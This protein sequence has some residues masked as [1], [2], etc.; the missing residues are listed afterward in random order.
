MQS[1]RLNGALFAALLLAVSLSCGSPLW[2]QVVG[3]NLNGIVS[4]SSG[5]SI[6]SAQISITDVATGVG[7]AVTTD[8]A[9]LYTAPNLPAGKYDVT[10]TA[11]GFSTFVRNGLTLTVGESL[12][13]NV[14]LQVGQVKQQV[15]VTGEAPAVET[16]SSEMSAVVNSA[17]IEDLP[18]NGRSWTDLTI[19]QRG[20]SLI[21]SGEGEAESG[22]CNH[23]CGAELSING[24]RP[25]QNNY[26]IDGISI[27]DQINSAP[28]SQAGGGNLGVDTIQEFSV[29]TDNQSAEYGRTAGGVINSITR[30]G[31]NDIHGTAFEFIRNSALDA[32]NFFDPASGPPEFR[33]NQFGGSFGGPIQK[34]KTFFFGAYE[35]LR[36]SLGFTAIDLVPSA[37][38]H[39]GIL[40]TG[41]VTVDP[42]IQLALK[43]FP[44]PNGK[45]ITPDQGQFIFIGNDVTNE[46]FFDGKV[47]HTFS[48]HDSISGT[49]Q[50]DRASGTNPDNFGI[51]LQENLTERQL[52]TVAETHIFSSTIVNTARFGWTRFSMPIGLSAGV[53]N[54]AGNNPA[55]ATVPGQPGQAAISIGAGFTANPGG[56][57]TQAHSF[58][59]FNTW[60]YHDDLFVTSGKHSLKFGVAVEHDQDIY[61]NSTATGGSWSFPGLAAFLQNEPKSLTALVPGNLTA[62]RLHTTIAGG[63][64]QD[65]FR[66]RPSLTLNLGLRYEMSTVPYETSGKVT[67]LSNLFDANPRIGNP[68]W[69]NP[70]YRNFEPRLGFAWDPFR[71]GKTSIRGGF[72]MF[73]V[74]PLF[75]EVTTQFA[76]GYPF[77]LVGATT[78]S[79][80]GPPAAG[81]G[82][83]PT[84]G[85]D[86]CIQNGFSSFRGL[87]FQNDPKRNYV[88]QWNMDIQH[89]LTPSV[90]FSVGYVGTKSVHQPTKS[91][92]VD[93]VEPTLTSAGWLWPLRVNG[94]PVNAGDRINPFYG[95]IKATYWLGDAN[96]N[97]LVTEVTKRMAHG[98]Q[99]HGAFTWAKSLDDTSTTQDGDSFTNS[100]GTPDLFDT[101]HASLPTFF[102]QYWYGRSD[103]NVARTLII[104]GLWQ[105]PGPKS[106]E[107][108]LG[109]VANG[110]QLGGIFTAHDGQPFTPTWGTGGNVTGDFG[111][112]NNGFVDQ[113]NTPGCSDPVNTQNPVNYIKT[114]CFTLPAAPSMAF[115][116]ANC[117]P[118]LGKTV[119]TFPT[120]VN[121]R[122]TA[123]RNTVIGPGLVDL[124]Y[125]VTK[126]TY[127]TRIS[128][129]FNIQFRA[130]VFNIANRANFMPPSSTDIFDASANPI[131]AAGNITKTATSSR[132]IQFGL[133]L[134]W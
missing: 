132:Q 61:D 25:Q 62:R 119:L 86:C 57:D 90:S 12:T 41:N 117:A 99:L 91:E 6:V 55:S 92:E 109:F 63:Y 80:T 112:T 126:N 77:A 28:G 74:L 27:N 111:S 113:L 76:Q 4:D 37:N 20:V 58:N 82:L 101:N 10:V 2:A 133:K 73:D 14:T 23:G 54:P 83:F 100:V 89:Q 31:T 75:S 116:T 3:A 33:R 87:Q 88:M 123:G 13:L 94:A 30:S 21:G 52:A 97:G 79:V 93:I 47:D 64:A 39:N 114:S 5:G 96:Y 110:W 105:I 102:K 9:G 59:F 48:A 42:A 43:L 32:R 26:R 129:N 84:L 53:I 15:E 120:C 22:F 131:A 71:A 56:L 81:Q 128:E 106:S 127:V 130:E 95:S 24:G 19:L 49:Y 46:D 118:T 34:N 38:A 98:F 51:Q 69:Q 104:D 45:M 78:F 60:Q 124:D 66:V 103:F 36:Q 85:Y 70:T 11:P 16:S 121:L 107:G 35:G 134:I 68:L 50:H 29:I 18:L 17:T 44:T 108:V 7:R 8:S 72:G 67:V 65:D 1:Q 122:G 40:S 125:S 115:W